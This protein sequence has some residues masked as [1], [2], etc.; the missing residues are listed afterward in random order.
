M[1]S[2]EAVYALLRRH[3][4]LRPRAIAE[5]L[6]ISVVTV[7]IAIKQ[8]E[9]RGVVKRVSMGRQ[10][11]VCAG[12]ASPVLEIEKKIEE[13]KRRGR[14]FVWLRDLAKNSK[15][16]ELMA[17]VLGKRYRIEKLRRGYLLYLV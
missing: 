6:G 9:E 12:D 5:T 15:E 16:V 13:L 3:G 7:Y 4:C 2:V 17:K 10:Y 8:L 11:Y 14:K 1:S